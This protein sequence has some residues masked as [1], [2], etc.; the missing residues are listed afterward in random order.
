[1]AL[2]CCHAT[3]RCLLICDEVGL[4]ESTSSLERDK[5]VTSQKPAVV[6]MLQ[7]MCM[8]CSR[9]SRA[10]ITAQF[11]TTCRR[12]IE[13]CFVVLF[14]VRVGWHAIVVG[15]PTIEIYVDR[16]IF[17]RALNWPYRIRLGMQNTNDCWR[18][19]SANW[20]QFVYL[21][22]QMYEMQTC[23]GTGRFPGIIVIANRDSDQHAVLSY[24]W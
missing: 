13:A 21:L 24:L 14:C 8:L 12:V 18:M 20:F 7:C 15:T 23:K 6:F 10:S 2:R 5:P 16:T 19:G 22:G 9:I 11:N 4:I 1:M 3:T 17:V